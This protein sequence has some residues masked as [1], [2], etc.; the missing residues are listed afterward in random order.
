[1]RRCVLALLLTMI[2][3]GCADPAQRS[4]SV[5]DIYAASGLPYAGWSGS[6]HWF[7]VERR[8][9][10]FGID[11]YIYVAVAPDGAVASHTLTSPVRW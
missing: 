2:P 8:P 5:L 9:G 11:L 4:A 1:M 3:A 6:A 10:P 7:L